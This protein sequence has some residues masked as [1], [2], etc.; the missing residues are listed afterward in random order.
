MI[1]RM[2][3]VGGGVSTMGL[4]V[5]HLAIAL[6]DI[7]SILTRLAKQALNDLASG[8][9]KCLLLIRRRRVKVR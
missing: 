8:E 4:Q 6:Q 1:Q 9:I 5:P 3:V 2:E 7:I